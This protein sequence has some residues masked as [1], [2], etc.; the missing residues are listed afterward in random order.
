MAVKLVRRQRRD[1]KDTC[2]YCGKAVEGGDA[3][4]SARGSGI[5]YYHAACWQNIK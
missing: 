4:I 1:A 5:S 3:V 2:V